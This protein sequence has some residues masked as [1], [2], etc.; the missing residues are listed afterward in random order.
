MMELQLYFYLWVNLQILLIFTDTDTV[1]FYLQH[2]FK[3]LSAL[4]ASK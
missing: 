3:A 1:Y 2:F 4:T